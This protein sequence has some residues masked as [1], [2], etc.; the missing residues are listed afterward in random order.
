M[1]VA[2]GLKPAE[3]VYDPTYLQFLRQIGVTH[4]LGFMY[5]ESVLPSAKDG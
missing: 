5:D 1:K 2:V 4:I 3:Q